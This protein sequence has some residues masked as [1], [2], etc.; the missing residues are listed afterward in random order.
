MQLRH[1]IVDRSLRLNLGSAGLVICDGLNA[2]V[3]QIVTL[4][5][6]FGI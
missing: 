6:V 1:L 4:E 3:L 2:P 5:D